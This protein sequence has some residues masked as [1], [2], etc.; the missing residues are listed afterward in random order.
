MLQDLR[1]AFRSLRRRSPVAAVAVVTLGL[2]I[3][4][5]SAVFSVVEA[6]LLRPLPFREPDRLVRIWELTRDGDRFSFSD[7]NYL[8]LRA[9]SRTLQRL[10]AYRDLGVSAVLADGGEPQRIAAVPVSASLLDVLGVRPQ[11][12]RMFSDDEDRP[13]MAERRVMLSDGLWRRRF[14]ADRGIVGRRVTLDGEPFLVTGVMPP[15]FDFPGGAD[16]WIPL[17]A[18]SRS[19]RGNKELAVIGRLASGATLAQLAGELR[20]IARRIS[21]ESPESNAGWSAG[22]VPF[23]E[24]IVA[25]RF[26]DSVWVLFAAVVVAARVRERRQPARCAGRV[27]PGGD[28]G[29]RRARRRPRTAR[30]AALYGIRAARRARNGRGRAHRRLVRE[31]RARTR[32]R[33]HPST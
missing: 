29:P 26:R 20:E 32:R 7:P 24:W 31:C 15:Q 16:A 27:A 19:D 9:E 21:D 1:Y 23:S 3:G 8:D 17:A 30:P 12:G 4:G 2:G 25:P 33:P 11:V 10:A 6:V 22:A 13:G 28:A 14:S 18:D 5:A